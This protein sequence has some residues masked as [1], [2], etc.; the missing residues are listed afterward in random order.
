MNRFRYAW[1]LAAVAVAAVAA[2]SA[3]GVTPKKPVPFKGTYTGKAVVQTSGQSATISANGAGAVTPLGRSTLAGKGVGSQSDPCPLFGGTASLTGKLG[4]INFKVGP[5][6]GNAC[7][8]EAGTLFAL[9]G[10]ATIAGGTKKY[11]HAKGTFKFTGNY[12]KGT[13]HFTV[14]FTGLVTV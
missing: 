5:A 10:R 11:L 1:V 13:G 4:K 3:L 14:K 8:D 9:S 2:G 12:D 7:T 6:S